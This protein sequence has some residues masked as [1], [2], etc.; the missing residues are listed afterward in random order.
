MIQ[1]RCYIQTNATNNMGF[2][3]VTSQC[4]QIELLI[5]LNFQLFLFS[6]YCANKWFTLASH[7]KSSWCVLVCIFFV[8]SKSVRV[9]RMYFL[10]VYGLKISNALSII[11]INVLKWIKPIVSLNWMTRFKLN[12][13]THSSVRSHSQQSID[14]GTHGHVVASE[15]IISARSMNE[16]NKIKIKTL[17][18]R[19]VNSWKC[20]KRK[21]NH[22]IKSTEQ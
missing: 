12:T 1:S 5:Q 21:R 10:R 2:G 19:K 6:F 16:K 7:G 15:H 14:D 3:K 9:E 22:W 11:I 13:H 17:Q 18:S 4:H 8:T 20:N